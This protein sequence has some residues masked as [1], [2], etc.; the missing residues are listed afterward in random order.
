MTVE[1]PKVLLQGV[2]WLN[3]LGIGQA[4]VGRESY[5]PWD[6][7]L[8]ISAS[9]SLLALS[10]VGP[11]VARPEK[12]WQLVYGTDNDGHQSGLYTKFDHP[13]R[14]IETMSVDDEQVLSVFDWLRQ[15][16]HQPT[17]SSIGWTGNLTVVL[18][19][20]NTICMPAN[21][22]SAEG[23]IMVILPDSASSSTATFNIDL[24]PIPSL[25]FTGAACS[26]TFRQGLYALKVWIVD[27]QGADLSFNWYGKEWDQHIVYEPVT[28]S[29]LDIGRALA[30]QARDSLPRI[31]TLVPST[32][33]LAQFVLM[34]RMLQRTDPTINSDDAGMSI[35]LGVLLQNL[36]STSNK[37][38]SPLPSSLPS[39]HSKKITSYPL[40][41]Q[42]YGSGP[43]LAW[44]WAAVAVLVIVLLS[45]CL[46]MYQ[47]LRYW[48][49]PGY[50]V[51]LDGMM[52]IAQKSPP[53]ADIRD[54]EKAR[55]RVY[56]VED[57]TTG[58]LVLKSK[59]G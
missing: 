22:S 29:N 44:E 26:S 3:L 4:N 48:M 13:G 52:V 37:Y 57:D 43:R 41:W 40:Q 53:L 24:G 34:S 33:L 18:P 23:S 17:A 30:I 58:G 8:G 12:G 14:P 35:V 42:L 9:Q 47:T 25:N 55:K 54:E 20:L 46:G 16:H 27:M 2:D 28:P 1:Y 38:W 49:A 51:Q 11:T 45:F 7:A 56:R 36:V 15:T 5:P 59:L 39:E 32:G 31:E 10:N 50:W 19:A 21:R 6:W